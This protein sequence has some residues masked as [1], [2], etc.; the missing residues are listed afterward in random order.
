M[1]YHEIREYGVIGDMRTAA[2]VSRFGSIDW[3]CFPRFDSTSLFA[4][5]LDDGRGGHWSVAPAGESGAD[6]RYEAGTNVLVTRFRTPTGVLEVTDFMPVLEW[7]RQLASHHEIHR[8]LRVPE[9]R[10][11]VATT[12]RPRFDYAQRDPSFR[13]R[14][15]GLLA[16][17]GQ[18]EAVTVAGI[19]G[20]EWEV[21][22]EAREARARLALEA[23]EARA[24]VLRYDDDE[25]WPR[26]EYGTSR[27]LEETRR[28]WRDWS[29][30]IRYRGRYRELV[31][32][33]ALTLKLL[34]YAP[35]GA[36]VA[37]PTTSLP[38]VIGGGRNW[39]YRYSWLRDSTYTL[40]ALYALGKFEELDRYMIYLKKVCR[41]ESDYMQIMFGVGGEQE[42]PECELSHLSGYR[43]SAPVRIGNAAAGQFQLDI[44]GEV[45]DSVHIWRKQH[46]M[47]EGMW[48]LCRR[49]AGHVIRKWREPDRGVWEWRGE[50]RHFVFSKVMAWVALDRAIQI[51][52]DLGLDGEVDRW[53]EER[54]AIRAEVLEKGWSEE[55]GAFVLYYG[56]DRLDSANLTLPLVRFLPADHPRVRS[57]VE[58]IAEELGGPG[59][60]LRR[61]D[62][63]DALQG[64]EGAFW[65]STFQLSQALALG[66]D[67]ERAIEVFERAIEPRSPLGLF[68]EQ[69]DPETGRLLGNFP[70]AFTH[71]GLVNAAHV[72]ARTRTSERPSQ[73]ELLRS[74]PAASA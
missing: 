68:S 66:G 4:R 74:P 26:E 56:S 17:D 27:K 40:F 52:E 39:D 3:C 47:T 23:G 14:A 70:Q 22:E 37:A 49:L 50:P 32:R 48:E 24:L 2:L 13:I 71:I 35:T 6:H 72:I 21:D 30:G 45:L 46:R 36:I 59:G 29:S 11:E 34:F 9:G 55:K 60:H 25:V 54:A 44:Y 12:F 67:R 43:D 63:D 42:L 38:E 51:A 61:Y 65:V 73:L 7:N 8:C 1:A 16:T 33:S 20:S 41:M 58:R 31:E 69:V 64:R 28:F 62:G 10:V 5:I 15:H 53:R 18:D 57:T 19:R